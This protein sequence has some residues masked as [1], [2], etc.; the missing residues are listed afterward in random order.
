M[1]KWN[2]AIRASAMRAGLAAAVAVPFAVGAA[3]AAAAEE[4]A[5]L[6]VAL[7][8]SYAAGAGVPDQSAGLCA[9][10]DRNYPRLVAAK[11]DIT[12]VRDVTCAG[13]KIKHMTELQTYPVV[14]KVNDP[15][16]NAVTAQ[17]KLVT[18]TIGGNDLGAGDLGM[19]EVLVKCVALAATDPAGAPCSKSYGNTLSDRI[20]AV[21]PAIASAVTQ[22]RE[23]APEA[24]VLLVGYPAVLPEDHMD[25]LFKQPITVNDAAF[26]RDRIKELN[27]LLAATAQ[28]SGATYVDTYTPSIGHDICQVP[29][30]RWIEGITPHQPAQPIHPN[31]RGQQAMADAVT[32]ALR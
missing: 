16:L 1:P 20:D 9:R 2:S 18:L 5:G 7:G 30:E 31:A 6:Y 12:D 11:A 14:G 26:L 25:C 3:P 23:R 8:D 24:K 4:P 22:I 13:A 28:Q 10:S 29:W 19:A 32:A 17:T 15:Q 27:S 21:A